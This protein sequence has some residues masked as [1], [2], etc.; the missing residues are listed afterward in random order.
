MVN[1]LMVIIIIFLTIKR[2]LD[3]KK[4]DGKADK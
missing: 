2:M 4:K 1:T 3:K